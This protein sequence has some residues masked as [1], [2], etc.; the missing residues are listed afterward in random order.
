MFSNTRSAF[1]APLKGPVGVVPKQLVQKTTM[2]RIAVFC[3]IPKT[4]E[5]LLV[6]NLSNDIDYVEDRLLS[7]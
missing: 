2:V 5:N 4:F 3:Q 7:K 6:S 1:D